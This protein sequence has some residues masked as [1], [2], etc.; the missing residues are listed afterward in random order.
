MLH[1]HGLIPSWRRRLES[2][3]AATQAA[4]APQPRDPRLPLAFAVADPLALLSQFVAPSSAPLASDGEE[5]VARQR[6][7][8][9]FQK[10]R[11]DATTPP[12]PSQVAPADRAKGGTTVLGR[13]PIQPPTAQ[14]PNA[15]QTARAQLAGLPPR[16]NHGQWQALERQLNGAIPTMP[17]GPHTNGAHQTSSNLLARLS[18][19]IAAP[20]S[21]APAALPAA[22]SPGS[23]ARLAQP[24]QM[25]VAPALRAA[26]RLRPASPPFH[27]VDQAPQPAGPAPA[28]SAT[29]S[30][31]HTMPTAQLHQLALPAAGPA[32]GAAI[33]DPS[34]STA[35][36]ASDGAT[37]APTFNG[38]GMAG[39]AN[40]ATG[41]PAGVQ[42]AAPHTAWGLLQ[43]MT[44][45]PGPATTQADPARPNPIAAAVTTVQ[46]APIAGQPAASNM[47]APGA[48]N[49]PLLPPAVQNTFNVQ[50]HM[51]G[52][53]VDENELANQLNRILQTQ[54]RR[55]GIEL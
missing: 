36:A 20:N 37:T 46:P 32:Q 16:L 40:Q 38:R 14:P 55:F 27:R 3:L 42:S 29:V 43:Q 45:R 50:V 24:G 26:T 19:Q 23:A 54:A 17:T 28:R 34:N 5:V 12:R 9:A 7:Q 44:R 21:A 8:L 10:L 13:R 48:P 31:R 18:Q 41:G 6:R 49:G 22:A 25:P 47:P 51:E 2:Q 11:H 33:A 35:T 15:N 53:T 52:Q 1:S 30:L 4:I 39:G